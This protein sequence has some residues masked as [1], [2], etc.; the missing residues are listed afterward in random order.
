MF[1]FLALL[2]LPRVHKW[3]VSALHGVL[4]DRG[5]YKKPPRFLLAYPYNRTNIFLAHPPL[6]H[7]QGL[8]V[9]AR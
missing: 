8:V 3:S 1:V 5:E 4:S 2:R 7:Q 6:A 9:C